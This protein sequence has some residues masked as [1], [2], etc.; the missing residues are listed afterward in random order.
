MLEITWML[1]NCEK[2]F[3][4]KPLNYFS[5]L[6]G[7]EGENSL[8]SYLKEEGLAMALSAGCDHELSAF[9]TLTVEV[10][11]TK[12]GLENHEA[13]IAAVFKYAKRLSEAGP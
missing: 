6:F 10:T 8:M 3:L 11:L 9:S 5:H 4:T 7:H 1:P 12:K 2:E 13:V